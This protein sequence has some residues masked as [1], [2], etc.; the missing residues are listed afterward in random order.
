MDIITS[1][2]GDGIH[3]DSDD[4]N[5]NSL[6]YLACER[7]NVEIARTLLSYKVCPARPLKSG[8]TALH[9]AVRQGDLAMLQLFEEKRASSLKNMTSSA[10][11]P[12]LMIAVR[13]GHLELVKH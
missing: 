3:A 11:E 8:D 7:K 1:L 6:L 2:L 10:G 4:E 5:G 9:L 12:L 13:L